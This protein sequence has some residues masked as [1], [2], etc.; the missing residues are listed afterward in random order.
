MEKKHIIVIGAG[1]GGLTA[2]MIL[3]KRGFNVSVLEAQEQVGGR[4]GAFQLGPYTFDIGPTFLM[5]KPILDE[6]FAEAGADCDKLMDLRE[7][8]P[9]Y[10][11]QFDDKYIEPINDPEKMKSEIARVFPGMEKAYALFFERE[12]KRFDALYPCLQKSYHSK[13][14]FLSPHLIKA[15]PHL[16][17]GKSLYDIMVKNFRE[18]KLALSFTF[19][20]KYLGM[21]PWECP[22]LFAIIPYIEHAFG[23]YHPIGGLSRISDSMADTARANGAQIRLGAP[24]KQI[25]V[26]D[27]AARGAVLENGEQIEADEVIIN[28]DFAYAA[29]TLFAPGVLKKYSPAKLKKKKFSCSTFMLYL[30][31]N[32][33]YDL[34]HHTIFFAEDYRKNVDDIFH[35]REPDN[36]LSVYVRN[37][38]VTDPTLAPEGHS[39]VYVLVPMPNLRADIDWKAKQNNFR[40]TVLDIMEQRG[41]MENLREHIVE[42]KV[43]TPESWRDDL[44]VFEGAT[45][46]LAHSWDQMIHLR[47]RNKFEEVDNCYLTGG[48]TH[49]GSGLPTIYESGRIAANLISRKYAVPFQSANLLT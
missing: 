43:M 24:V 31:L 27:G 12:K 30:G 19:Q 49:P 47:P 13:R 38:S 44:N 18:E 21:S 8:K 48:G 7:L 25:L 17:I 41:G 14:S 32:K 5:L 15:V 6:V 36:N 40:E 1:P 20:A 16:A 45:F 22:G 34:P 33:Q 28:A 2:A 42:E 39:A 9:M 29:S 3:A 4:N 46:N 37:A 23:I 26:R 10:R 11:L 35:L